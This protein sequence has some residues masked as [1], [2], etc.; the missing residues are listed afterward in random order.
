MENF[1]EN[2]P[3]FRLNKAGIDAGFFLFKDLRD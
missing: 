3:Y 2:R 1:E